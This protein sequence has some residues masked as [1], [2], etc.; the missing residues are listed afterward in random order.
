M[1]HFSVL[2]C[3]SLSTWKARVLLITFRGITESAIEELVQQLKQF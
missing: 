2:I 1:S 3:V